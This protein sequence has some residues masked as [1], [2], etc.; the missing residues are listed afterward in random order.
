MSTPKLR[1]RVAVVAVEH[2][3]LALR[4]AGAGAT[5]VLVGDDADRAGRI[6]ATIHARASGRG[7]YFATGPGGGSAGDADALVELVA[8]QFR[9]EP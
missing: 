9:V 3:E 2:E 7:A 6:L 8:E 4:L 1:G 5:V